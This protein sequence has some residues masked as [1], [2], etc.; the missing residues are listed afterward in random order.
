M[1]E[2][3]VRGGAEL[4]RI[5]LEL[6]R[7]GGGELTKKLRRELR[8]AAQPLVPAVRASIMQI[9]TTGD[10]STGLRRQMA[11]A[12]KLEMK[13]TGRQAGIAIRVD[14]RKMPSRCGRLPSYMEG[15]RKRWR[16]PVYGNRN[17][18]VGQQAHPYFYNVVRNLGPKSHAAIQK[19]LAEAT[20]EIS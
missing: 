16:H 8:K 12:T 2:V 7:M 19:A 11:K 10:K 15:T 18:W 14:G 9:P 5:S 1:P 3:E 17:V 13:T 6:R 20:R 4:R